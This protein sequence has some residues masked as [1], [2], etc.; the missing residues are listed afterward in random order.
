[1]TGFTLG[2]AGVRESVGIRV[3]GMRHLISCMTHNIS[4]RITLFIWNMIGCFM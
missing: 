3:V 2:V 4:Y 1:M